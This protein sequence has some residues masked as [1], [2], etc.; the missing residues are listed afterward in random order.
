[1]WVVSSFLFIFLSIPFPPFLSFILPFFSYNWSASLYPFFFLT[2][3]LF[4]VHYSSFW[5]FLMQTSYSYIL[6]AWK[7]W[8]IRNTRN[9]GKT[10]WHLQRLGENGN[11]DHWGKLMVVVVVLGSFDQSSIYGN[12]VV[13][14]FFSWRMC[15]VWLRVKKSRQDKWNLIYVK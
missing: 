14:S 2:Y 6:P 4:L 1:M 5:V 11:T 15:T 9:Q 12:P 8:N 7:A 3:M 10:R 13:F